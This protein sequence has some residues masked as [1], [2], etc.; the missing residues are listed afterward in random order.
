MVAN[1]VDVDGLFNAI[2]D[3]SKDT[4]NISFTNSTWA[5]AGR[6]W[7]QGFQELDWYDFLSVKINSIC[8]EGDQRFPS[9]S[10]ELDKIDQKS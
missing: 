3:T 9:I 8:T 5:K 4:S 10:C 2:F 6:I 7:K 1:I